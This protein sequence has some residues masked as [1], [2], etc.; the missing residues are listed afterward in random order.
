MSQWRVSGTPPIFC[1]IDPHRF[2]PGGEIDGARKRRQHHELREG[3]AGALGHRE[4]GVEGFGPI[5]RQAEN[6]RPEHVNAVL[7]K[8]P[9]A[10]DE[11]LSRVVEVLV[12]VLQPFRRHRLHADERPLDAGAMHGA[13]ELGILRSF[14]RD[15]REEHHVG[16]QFGELV[17]Q[18]EPLGALGLERLETRGVV[19]PLGHA[20]I[21][22]RDR[23]EIVVGK[24]DEPEAAPAQLDDLLDDA[25]RSA[26][27]R[28][29]AIGAPDRAERAVFRAA[30]NGLHRTP[31]VA[32]RLHEIPA[33]RT[34]F[35]RVDA[36]AFV[37]R[38]QRPAKAIGEGLRPG[39]L[40]VSL[41]HGVRTAQSEC[42]V[43]VKR[44]VDPA[45]NHECA[46][47][48]RQLPHLVS[49]QGVAGMDADAHHVTGLDL[50]RCH[51]FEHFVGEPRRAERRRGCA[52]EHV[53][54]AWRDDANAKRDMTGINEVNAHGSLA[55]PPRIPCEVGEPP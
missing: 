48:A 37:H 24:G 55:K 36:P 51:R 28:L 39:A 46:G 34:E 50:A 53:Q 2:L 52:C 14:H 16:G 10:L 33:G 31:H 7:L 45:V 11:G 23:I 27:A 9:E 38:L 40:A 12:D 42:L 44:R 22:Q 20:Q 21:F 25:V 18:G 54:P 47:L 35:L 41:D 17:H 26:L 6:E 13:Q 43:R 5:G 15:L 30:A 1:G 29:L 49:A 8:G 4:G 32:T 3:Q 19:T